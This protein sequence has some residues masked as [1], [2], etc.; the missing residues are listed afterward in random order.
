MYLVNP[1][2]LLNLYGVSIQSTTEANIIRGAYG[3]LFLLFGLL[4]VLGALKNNLEHTAQV[5]LAL[6]MG[7]FA[8]GRL[9][10]FVVDGSPHAL[11]IMLFIA[12]V[13]YASAAMFLIKTRCNDPSGNKANQ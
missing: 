5:A 11:L 8:I 7:G 9:V 1:H 10:S 4:F 2:L 6:F 13:I 12:E 3:G